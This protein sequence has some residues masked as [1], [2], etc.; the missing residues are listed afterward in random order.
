MTSAAGASG[1]V[2][3][4]LRVTGGDASR[5]PRPVIAADCVVLGWTKGRV[6][7]RHLRVAAARGLS[8]RGAGLG[9]ASG[10]RPQRGLPLRASEATG[11]A[12]RPAGG[13]A[14]GRQGGPVGLPGARLRA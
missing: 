12:A 3:R 6:P 4:L 13:R 1:A 8:R 9:E 2:C 10:D 11:G 14:P 5:H 7:G